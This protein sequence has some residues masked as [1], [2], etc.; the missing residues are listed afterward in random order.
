M[1]IMYVI[2]YIRIDAMEILVMMSRVES[3]K[4]CHLDIDE[5]L[6]LMVNDY[7]GYFDTI[8]WY[9]DNTEQSE[10]E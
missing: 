1:T 4:E 6:D 2:G 8:K 3:K 7:K 10:I 9:F 5:F